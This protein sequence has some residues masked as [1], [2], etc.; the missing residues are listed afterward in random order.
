MKK[1]KQEHPLPT[2]AERWTITIEETIKMACYYAG[3]VPN[4]VTKEEWEK[5]ADERLTIIGDPFGIQ[6]LVLDYQTKN[7]VIARWDNVALTMEII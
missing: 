3:I 4:E 2:M 6:N 7:K 1:T 5:I